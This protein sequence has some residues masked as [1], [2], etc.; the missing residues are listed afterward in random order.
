MKAIVW[1]G[2]GPPDV[3]QLREVAKPVPN[4]NQVLIRIDATTATKADCELRGLK[5]PLALMLPLRLYLGIRRP[6]IRIPGQ[7]LAGEIEAVGNGVTRFAKGDPVFAWTG[8]RLGAYAE[9]TCLPETAALSIKPTNMTFEQ[10]APLAVGGLEAT[11]FMRK[12]GIRNGQKVLVNGAGG[13]IGSFAIQLAKHF[14]ADVTGVDSTE[15]LDMLRSI[16]ADKVI[17]YTKQDFTESGERYE[18]IFDVVGT[19]SFSQYVK[20]LN[21]DGRLLLGNPGLSQQIGARRT[22]PEGKQVISWGTRA[23]HEI[24][25]DLAFL[26]ELVEA[27][28]IKSVIDRRYPLEQTADAHRYVETGRKKGN[29]VINL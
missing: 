1:T 5:V 15:K 17:D 20:S 7:E 2:Y 29:V 19:N 22:L 26:K 21:P 3:L 27:G 10:A 8:F 6:R 13:S 18:V 16:G 24:T 9:Y 23:A 4:D 25:D 14:G 12:A 11:H 28:K